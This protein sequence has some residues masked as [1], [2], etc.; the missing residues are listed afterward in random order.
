M[1]KRG[2]VMRWD[3]ERAFGFIRSNEPGGR[4]GADVFFHL[5]DYQGS[6]APQK[7]QQVDY[8]EILVGGKGPRAMAVRAAGS[9]ATP[10]R[11]PSKRSSRSK[12]PNSR[13]RSAPAAEGAGL[14]MLLMLSW[15]CLLAWSVWTQHLPL[16]L[17]LVLAGLN[18]LTY[19][20]YAADKKAA[21]TGR[22]RVPEK[23][24]HTLALLGGWPAAWLAQQTMRHKSSK[25]A[26]RAVYWA[27]MLLNCAVLLAYVVRAGAFGR[28]L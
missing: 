26:F 25:T 18:L 3:A 9:A 8:E 22:R 16:W 10:S 6:S 21:R 23:Q 27:S 20:T 11:F 14:A 12:S 19:W 24:L 13:S 2:T 7:G 4:A 1:V 28:W 5:R 15:A 17:L